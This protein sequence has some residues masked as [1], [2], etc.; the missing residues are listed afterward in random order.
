MIHPNLYRDGLFLVKSW[1]K[2]APNTFWTMFKWSFLAIWRVCI[3]SSQ[4][5]NVHICG[6]FKRM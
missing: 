1:L 6:L 2:W 4:L 5:T 3:F